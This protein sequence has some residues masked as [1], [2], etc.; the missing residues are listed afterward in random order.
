LAASCGVKRW[1]G[2]HH[3]AES[4]I[5]EKTINIKIKSSDEVGGNDQGAHHLRT[6]VGDKLALQEFGWIAVHGCPVW[7]DECLV[8][9]KFGHV[10]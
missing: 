2:P 1:H 7:H 10:T 6:I 4:A 5:H 3:E 8:L 9:Q